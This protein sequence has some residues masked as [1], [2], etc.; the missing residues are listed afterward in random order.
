VL[1][2][3]RIDNEW[4]HRSL[5]RSRAYDLPAMARRIETLYSQVAKGALPAE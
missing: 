3:P 1:R 2:D 5:E 4:R